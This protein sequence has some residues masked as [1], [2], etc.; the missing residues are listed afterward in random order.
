MSKIV[1]TLPHHTVNGFQFGYSALPFIPP[2]PVYCYLIDG[3]LIDTASSNMQREVLAT[4]DSQKVTQIALTHSHEDHSGNV[5]A[6]KERYGATVYAGPLTIERVSKGFRLLP[7]ERYWFGQVAPCAEIT[8]FPAVI[9][10]ER[11]QFEPIFTPGHSPDHYVLYEKS[12]GWLF[13]GDAYIGNLKVF[14]RYEENIWLQIET[15]RQLLLLDFDTLFCC[16]NPVL[17]NGKAAL[18]RKLDYLMRIA[19]LTLELHQ[20][21]L[22]V[23]EITRRVGLKE[24]RLWRWLLSNDVAAEYIVQSVLAD[25]GTHTAHPST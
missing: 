13:A 10:T 20:Q 7:Y 3:L 21:G 15:L 5:T 25:L 17:S 24:N 9:E 12:Q 18:Q 2:V 22:P 14:R 6:L 16:H 8:P 23:R 4:F 1:R 11:Y 19:T